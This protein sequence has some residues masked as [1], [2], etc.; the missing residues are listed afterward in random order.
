[1][2]TFDRLIE[3]WELPNVN[4]FDNCTVYVD[5]VFRD[6]EVVRIS[7]VHCEFADPDGIVPIQTKTLQGVSTLLERQLIAE[8]EDQLDD[9][10]SFIAEQD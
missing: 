5:F 9:I 6:N 2:A 10:V 7:K 1:M 3:D 8:L 4:T